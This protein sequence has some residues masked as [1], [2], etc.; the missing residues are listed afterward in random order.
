[1][2]TA[3]KGRRLFVLHDG[4][5]QRED[6]GK[7]VKELTMACLPR[8]LREDDV[9]NVRVN[10]DAHTVTFGLNGVWNASPTFGEDLVVG[11]TWFIYLRVDEFIALK[12]LVDDVE[13]PAP[14]V[15]I[16]EAH[17]IPSPFPEVARE[18]DVSPPCVAPEP[19]SLLID[20]LIQEAPATPLSMVDV[21]QEVAEP[22]AP[23]ASLPLPETAQ[24]SLPEVVQEAPASPLPVPYFAQQVQ[25]PAVASETPVPPPCRLTKRGKRRKPQLEAAAKKEEEV[26]ESGGKRSLHRQFQEI[27]R[28]GLRAPR[29]KQ[30]TFQRLKR[31]GQEDV[32]EDGVISDEDDDDEEEFE[33][34]DDKRKKVRFA[35]MPHQS[36]TPM[37]NSKLSDFD[38]DDNDEGDA[39]DKRR[40]VQLYVPTQP[41]SRGQA[42]SLTEVLGW[43]PLR[44]SH[45]L[46]R[47][48]CCVRARL[49]LTR[50]RAQAPPLDDDEDG[51]EML[52]NMPKT[53]RDDDDDDERDE[54]DD[55]EEE[56]P[57][58]RPPTAQR[59]RLDP[60]E[61]IFL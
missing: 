46:V 57:P 48:P 33:V 61:E 25:T 43:A 58:P 2:C 36:T 50:K 18:P 14:R 39:R 26:T 1:M 32:E 6:H 41:P 49:L 38:F 5:A 21:V 52:M 17:A 37:E 16:Q 11:S 22:M 19:P 53:R 60:L 7:R 20:E 24:E 35:P 59:R 27:A 42:P 55:D 29:D 44:V 45:E 54:D 15:E 9:V 8:A 12:V 56:V 51:E 23:A 31:Q 47:R 4:C 10:L 3:P 13:A 34:P 40:L 30:A 28:G